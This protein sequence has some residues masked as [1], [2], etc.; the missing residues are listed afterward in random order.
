MKNMKILSLLMLLFTSSLFTTGAYAQENNTGKISGHVYNNDQTPAAF[1]TITLLRSSDSALVKSGISDSSGAYRFEKIP[2]GTYLIAASLTRTKKAYTKS[3]SLNNADEQ[4]T[5]SDIFL[6]SN[7]KVLEGVQVKA[8]KPFIQHKPGQTI[9]NIENSPVAAGNS[10]MEA[11]EKSPGVFVDQDGNISMNGKGG[12]NVMFNGQPTHL[13]ATQLSNMLKAMPASSVSQIELM[14]QPPAKYSAAGT[15]GLI[16]IVLKKNPSFGFNG[17]IT[18]GAGYGQFA[19]YNAGG[20]LNYKNKNFSLYSNYNFAHTKNKFEMDIDRYFYEPN[21]KI[22]QT[23]MDQ[24]SKMKTLNNNNTAQVGM[25]FYLTPKQTL[26]FVANGS[27]NDGEFNTY[28][29]VDFKNGSGIMDSVSTSRNHIGYSW[30]SQGANIH[31]TINSEKGSSLTANADYNNFETSMPQSLITTVTDGQGNQLH[32]T[33]QQKGTQPSNINIYAAKVDYTHPFKGQWNLSA[34]V[35]YSF[36]NS[37]NNSK[38]SIFKDNGWVND[39]GNTNHF[40]YKENVN[41]AYASLAKTFKNGWS[42]NAGLRGEQTITHTEQV[43]LDSANKNNYFNLFPNVSVTK[44]INPNHILSVSFARR[45]NRP[46]YQS[47][48]PFIYYIDEYTFRQGNAYLK[49]QFINSTE[50]SYTFKQ[51]YSA[52]LSYSRTSDIM[53]Q[54]IRQVDSAHKTFQTMD[55][56]STLDNLTLTLGIPLVITPWWHTYNSLQGYYNIYKGIYDGY[57]LHKGITSY[58]LY[59]QQTFIFP[60]GWKGDL[61]AMYKSKSI[62]GP[63]IL[64]PVAM[65]SA[66]ISKS[67]LKDKANIKLNVQDIFQ[68]MHFDGKINFGD[69]HANSVFRLMDRAANLTFTWNFGNQKVKVSQYK[70]TGIQQEE[71]RLK[72]ANNA[73]GAPK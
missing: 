23:R 42:A 7:T 65:V 1:A 61:S 55:N 32:D 20:S 66:G 28:S 57:D 27:F 21:T 26:G 71:N 45:I 5:A 34:G 40:I 19:K 22:I 10:V 18:A 62:M 58:M 44:M 48:N 15:A 47:L 35:K 17:N 56:L 59:S 43:S 31:Y 39:E 3:F 25:D 36:V 29:P 8:I 64:K 60:H 51:K 46:D 13:S 11:L 14:S 2:L 41:A 4:I 24:E 30:Q 16:N 33:K 54:V 69:I 38:F 73:T 67:L 53:T 50:L 68:T 49:P 72:S 37:D 63:A 9:V 12:V 70:N 52:V 6:A